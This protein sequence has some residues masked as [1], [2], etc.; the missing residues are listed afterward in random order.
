MRLVGGREGGRE[1]GK[2]GVS[3][4]FKVRADS[5]P[6]I[7]RS[8]KTG[9]GGGREGGREGRREGGRDVPVGCQAVGPHFLHNCLQED[10]H[11]Q[12]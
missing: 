3:R 11:P 12:H 5:R 1:G 2:E 4:E 10:H 8:W 7:F 9:K 6:S